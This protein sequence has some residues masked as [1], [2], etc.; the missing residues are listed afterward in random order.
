[1]GFRDIRRLVDFS[2]GLDAVQAV[3]VSKPLL[4]H[5]GRHG[6]K[7]LIAYLELWRVLAFL[8]NYGESFLGRRAVFFIDNNAMRDAIIRGSSPNIDM[9]CTLAMTSLN[10][11]V[12][13][14]FECVVRSHCKC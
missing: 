1:M 6:S 4:D 7:Q 5:W 11:S 10:I 8:H 13:E 3:Q 2:T 12:H 14:W 9:F